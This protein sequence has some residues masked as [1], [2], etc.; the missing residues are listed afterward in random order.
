MNARSGGR[1]ADSREG[2]IRQILVPAGRAF[3]IWRASRSLELAGAAREAV[4]RA[5][6]EGGIV[7]AAG[8]D[9][10]INTVAQEVLGSGCPFG[11]L[12]Q[13]TFNYFGRSHGI[14]VD[15][16]QAAEVLVRGK[17]RR[18][19][20]GLVNEKIFLV[21][22]SL[23]LY[24]RILEKREMHKKKFGR[25]RLVALFSALITL[26][27]PP[28][29]LS[30]TLGE[31]EGGELLQISTLLVENNPLQLEEVGL[32]EAE[33]VQRGNLAAVAVKA[34]G[35]PQMLGVLV[36][37]ALRRLKD[38]D[39]I[40]SFP[41]TEL[42]VK[43]MRARRIKVATDGEIGWLV[44]PLV[45]RAAPGGLSLLVPDEADRVRWER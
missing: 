7:V 24:P 25:T 9:G 18:V 17:L 1:D 21:N 41:F 16:V 34:K 45:F 8:G 44:P 36:L 31:A 39:R 2:A 10:T 4:R 43:H 15:T 12:P 29:V 13:G 5:R 42:T 40:L 26:F 28:P 23:G 27:T 19:Q 14:P 33:A 38:S 22:A 37:A 35:V 3:H 11:V 32:A 30:L 6:I 20:V